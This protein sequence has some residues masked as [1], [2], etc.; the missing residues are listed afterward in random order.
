MVWLLGWWCDKLKWELVR[1]S[2]GRQAT[3]DDNV[4]VREF[5]S[6]LQSAVFIRVQ[7]VY[8]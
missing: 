6:S 7:L 2:A 8:E 1:R 5:T 3:D 4:Y